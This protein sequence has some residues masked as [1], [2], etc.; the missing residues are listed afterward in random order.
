MDS[1]LDLLDRP[2]PDVAVRETLSPLL[3]RVSHPH[4]LVA[5]QIWAW[6]V[7]L[8][9]G[10]RYLEHL[11][12]LH[13]D[14]KPQNLM[15]TG[16]KGRTL[17]L[18]DFGVSHA[19]KPEVW[20]LLVVW[21]DPCALRSSSCIPLMLQE[22]AVTDIVGT[23]YYLSPELCQGKA[24]DHHADVWAAGVVL[25][26]LCTLSRPYSSDSVPSLILSIMKGQVR[27]VMVPR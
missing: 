9:A 12:I 22:D 4:A 17:K 10:L 24:Y 14:I 13:R 8:V 23:P 2:P 7:Q 16:Y 25:F 18:A 3:P 1:V 21:M 5:P 11:R 15:L 20:M 26:E 6:F 27:A 19:L